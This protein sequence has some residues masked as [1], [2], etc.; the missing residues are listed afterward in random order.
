M[1]FTGTLSFPTGQPGRPPVARPVEFSTVNAN[2]LVITTNENQWENAEGR[3]LRRALY[4]PILEEKFEATALNTPWLVLCNS[5][6]AFFARATRQ[7]LVYD[8]ARSLA[9]RVPRVPPDRLP[10]RC[11]AA[12]S[13]PCWR[14]R[15]ARCR[16]R[17]LPSSTSASLAAGLA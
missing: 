15:S 9:A 1:R 17:T 3:I 6:N 7:D 2:V 8:E 13:W 16:R 12:T 11:W 4:G 5:V 14:P 10:A